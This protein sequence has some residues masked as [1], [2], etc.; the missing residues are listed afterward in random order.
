VNKVC[1]VIWFRQQEITDNA[2]FDLRQC[3]QVLRVISII[4]YHICT[5][6]TRAFKYS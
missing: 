4:S 5:I 1:D 6:L 2:P 3:Q